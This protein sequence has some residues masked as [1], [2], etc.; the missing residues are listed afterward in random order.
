MNHLKVMNSVRK[1]RAALLQSVGLRR[2]FASSRFIVHASGLDRLWMVNDVAEKVI[3]CG[4]NVA[5][6]KA[7]KLGQYFSMMMLVEVPREHVHE[8]HTAMSVF[9]DMNVAVFEVSKTDALV[10]RV[11]YSASFSLEGADNPGIVHTITSA[12]ASHGLSIDRMETDQE[13]APHGGT[14]LF[15]M[16][17]AC[18]AYNP[19]PWSFDP[20]AI[21][22]DLRELG[23]SLNCEVSID[24]DDDDSTSTFIVD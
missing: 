4:G 5:E 21:K 8:L 23:D 6:S 22:Q 16:R 14:T 1:G 15:R 9:P 17:G 7:S 20:M 10:T 19:L 13:L 12:L 18:S 11:A 2:T 24:D 3:E